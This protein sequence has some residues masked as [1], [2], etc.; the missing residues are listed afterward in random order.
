MRQRIPQLDAVRGIAILVV[1]VHNNLPKYPTLPL[2][3]VFSYGWMGV[4]LFFVLSGFLITDILF[5]SKE[6]AGYFKNFYVRRCLRIWPLYFAVL[7]FMFVVVPLLRPSDGVLV[8]ARSSPWWAYLLFLQNF[9]GPSPTGA[10]GPLSVTWSLAIEEQFYLVWAVVVRCCS[11]AQLRRLAIM[12]ICLSPFVRFYLS[13]L[14][15]GLY[16]NVFCRLDGL[17]AG[18]L[19]ALVLRSSTFLPARFVKPVCL[20]LFVALPLVFVAEAFHARW[21]TYSLSAVASTAFV[22]VSLFST[23]KWFRL[24]M[25]TRTLTYTGRISYGLYLLHKIP[26]DAVQRF[27]FDLRP[28]LSLMIGFAASYALAILSW[29]LLEKPILGLGRFFDYARE[30]PA[31]ASDQLGRLGNLT[32]GRRAG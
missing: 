14:H 23:Q 15:V 10:V 8:F 7:F 11:Y 9:V 16:S 2:Q 12:V 1:L 3:R 6:S 19:L 17:M 29:N 4:D 18:S 5:D 21:I 32:G 28:F 25:T 26:F 20:S 30:G 13:R 24:A 31:L 27:H 22:Y